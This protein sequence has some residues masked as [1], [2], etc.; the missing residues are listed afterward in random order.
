[1]DEMPTQEDLCPKCGNVLVQRE[2]MLGVA[3]PRV[4]NAAGVLVPVPGFGKT[5]RQCADQHEKL[6]KEMGATHKEQ[7]KQELID[8]EKR[9]AGLRWRW[10]FDYG[11]PAAPK[12][13]MNSRTRKQATLR[14]AKFIYRLHRDG[15][16]AAGV[17]LNMAY[18]MEAEA[19]EY[20]DGSGITGDALRN[21]VKRWLEDLESKNPEL[22]RKETEPRPLQK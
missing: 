16:Y 8:A 6:M 10:L 12:P 9:A 4:L 2:D 7:R 15:G 22:H 21:A 17:S 19:R 11:P 20:E 1:M 18:Q 14:L 13:R 5:C 3:P